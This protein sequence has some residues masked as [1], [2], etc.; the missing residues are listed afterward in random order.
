MRCYAGYPKIKTIDGNFAT[1][2]Y[3][4]RNEEISA[5]VVGDFVQSY[6][7]YFKTHVNES[8]RSN[9]A[10]QLLETDLDPQKKAEKNGEKISPIFY[11]NGNSYTNN[12]VFDNIRA[13][14]KTQAEKYFYKYSV[15]LHVYENTEHML[16][17][18]Y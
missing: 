11:Y 9:N 2:R 17:T 16:L 14:K 8:T 4:H 1:Y 5:S 13:R 12:A 7:N 18:T 10:Y 3:N 6:N 15:R